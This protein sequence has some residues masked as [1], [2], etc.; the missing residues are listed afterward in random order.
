MGRGALQPVNKPNFRLLRLPRT[1]FKTM[2]T[3]TSSE[4]PSQKK[5]NI[6]SLFN[7][8][9]RRGSGEVWRTGRKLSLLMGDGTNVRKINRQPLC[10]KT[11]LKQINFRHGPRLEEMQLTQE[12]QDTHF[13]RG[14]EHTSPERGSYNKNLETRNRSTSH[15]SIPF[16][17]PLSVC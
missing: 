1:P 7:I 9:F 13:H 3:G 6:P 4:I 11:D 16:G 12:G 5:K 8:V 2:L 15:V 17:G 10:P 14:P